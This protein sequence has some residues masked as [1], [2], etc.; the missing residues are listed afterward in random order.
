MEPN[1][2]ETQFKEQLNSR[3]IKPSEMA[4][5]KLDAMLTVAEKPKTKFPWLFVAASFIGF[6]LIGTMFF[7]QK[8]SV[9][10]NQ[11]DGVV[12]QNSK[13]QEVNS[14]TTD[15]L[16]NKNTLPNAIKRSIQKG[17][18]APKYQAQPQ[19]GSLELEKNQLAAAQIKNSKNDSLTITL[20]NSNLRMEAKNKYV[21]ATALLAEVSNTQLQSSTSLQA[22]QKSKRTSTVTPQ[23]L[24]SDV[25][26]EMNQTFRESAVSKFNKNYNAIKTVLT[27]RNYEKE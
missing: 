25:E 14:T 27:N 7:N 22:T 1:K 13:N 26:T 16:Q 12:F 3:E 23:N 17:V 19:Q 24:L 18:V 15:T 4:W 2:L 6:F 8:E 5:S 9:N 10:V 11:E 21:S 20:E